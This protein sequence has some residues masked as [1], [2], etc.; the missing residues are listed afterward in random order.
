[1]CALPPI[2]NGKGEMQPGFWRG[3]VLAGLALSGI[4]ALELIVSAWWWR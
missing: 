4:L 1:M 2:E 3:Y